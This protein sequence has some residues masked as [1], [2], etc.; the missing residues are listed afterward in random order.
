MWSTTP[1]AS[2]ISSMVTAPLLWLTFVPPPLVT[3]TPPSP[4]PRRGACV[5][6]ALPPSPTT[7][8]PSSA[9]TSSVAWTWPAFL[10]L[11]RSRRTWQAAMTHPPWRTSNL[12]S[13]SPRLIDA[14]SVSSASLTNLSL[15]PHHPRPPWT[16]AEEA[17]PGRN[18][19]PLLRHHLPRGVPTLALISQSRPAFVPSTPARV[20]SGLASARVW[21][22]TPIAT[23]RGGRTL[24]CP[25]FR[26]LL[27]IPP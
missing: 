2:P 8:G 4:P 5:P 19:A 1:P 27:Q 26:L 24:R 15:P 3:L 9:L 12:S 11:L 10:A 6:S 21:P 20:P 14:D 25:P 22:L 18:T 13:H 16:W 17:A 7:C 23:L